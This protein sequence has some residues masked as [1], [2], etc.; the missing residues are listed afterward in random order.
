MALELFAMSLLP[1]SADII[2]AGI[3]G[4]ASALGSFAVRKGI[5]VMFECNQ[6]DEQRQERICNCDFNNL[7]CPNCKKLLKQYTNACSFTVKE[8]GKIAHV[9]ASFHGWKW[10]FWDDRHIIVPSHYIFVGLKG[11]QVVERNIFRDHTT[12]RE[13]SSRQ[14]EYVWKPC[15]DVCRNT[16]ARMNASTANVH[17]DPLTHIELRME[18]RFGDVLLTDRY[19]IKL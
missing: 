19:C 11:I 16:N 2:A 13:L 3:K 18:S 7:Q 12:G 14:Y 15:C 1:S 5:D 6:C 8:T 10:D 4:A 9:G 17:G